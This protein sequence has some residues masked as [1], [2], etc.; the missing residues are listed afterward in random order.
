MALFDPA[1]D[2][3]HS[4]DIPCNNWLSW[5]ARNGKLHLNVAIRS[6]DAM[7][8]FSGVN[9]FEWSILQ[10]MMAYWLGLEVGCADY[11]ATS[12]HLYDQHFDRARQIGERFHRLTPYEFGVSSAAFQTSW[13]NFASKLDQWFAL[14][15]QICSEP[16]GPLFVHGRTNDPLLDSGLALVHVHWAH[17]KWG[18]ER[19]AKEL[20]ALPAKDYV[21]AMYEQ[22]GR[23]YPTLL[24]DIAQ[25]PIARFIEACRNRT[26]DLP[27]AF[28]SAVKRLHVVKDRAYGSAWKRRGELAG[29]LPNIARKSDRLEAIIATGA[30][31]SSE[32][33]LDT[34]IDLFVYVEKY[35]LFLAEGLSEGTLL[36]HGSPLP[37]S[38]HDANFDLLVDRLNL[39]AGNRCIEEIVREIADRFDVCWQA[40]VSNAPRSERL[41]VTTMLAESAGQLVARLVADDK[42]AVARFV[43]SDFLCER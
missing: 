39:N 24:Q 31:M 33:T 23:T 8:G 16:D 36:P 3:A 29:I 21:A 9:A 13:E 11:F 28:K 10:E 40:A 7:W 14:E 18:A 32:T 42:A 26:L 38:S 30:R 4:K 12:F 1:R 20:A 37:L 41:G 6:S 22:F 27:S 15:E 34:A 43:E 19:L 25:P 5:I 2:F 17:K 35:R